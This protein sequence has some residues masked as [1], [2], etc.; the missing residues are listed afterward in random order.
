MAQVAEHLPGNCGAPRNNI[1]IVKRKN[2]LQKEV[3]VYRKHYNFTCT[4]P[5]LEHSSRLFFLS[6]PSHFTYDCP[7]FL[8][9]PALPPLGLNLTLTFAGTLFPIPQTWVNM[10]A[11]PGHFFI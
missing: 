1:E 6:I 3:I 7:T 9:L 10:L 11:I 4:V 2:I 5:Y 8:F